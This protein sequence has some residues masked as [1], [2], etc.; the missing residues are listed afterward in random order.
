MLWYTINY[1][2]LYMKLNHIGIAVRN[3]ETALPFY[4]K[5]FNLQV[6]LEEVPAMKVRTAKLTVDNTVLELVQPLEGEQAVS[7]FLEKRGEGIHHLCF[8]VADI[9]QMM[10]QLEAT[11]YKPLYP[12]PKTGAGGHL[13]N[14]LSPKDTSGV[15][16]EILQAK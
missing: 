14:F 12:E 5:G 11:G 9:K 1:F 13:V 4:Q 6:Y 15:L 16:I 3:I 8:E 7:K 2:L 10:V